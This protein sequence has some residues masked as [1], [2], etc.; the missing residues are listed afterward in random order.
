MQKTKEKAT[1]KKTDMGVISVTDWKEQLRDSELLTLPSG[2]TVRIR[3]K[4]SLIDC[5]IA[6]YIPMSSLKKAVE[7]VDASKG[8]D[9]DAFDS[10]NDD[11]IAGF[12][13]ILRRVAV[14]LIMEPKLSLIDEANSVW[15]HDISVEDLMVVFNS[16][17]EA[18]GEGGKE[19][20][21][22]FPEERKPSGDS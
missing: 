13:D 10:M 4:V 3:K 12:N 19:D 22:P 2:A 18:G 7:T 5:A 6:G 20:L 8:K 17:L 11:E 1:P 14:R 21:S 9:A 15:V 16:F